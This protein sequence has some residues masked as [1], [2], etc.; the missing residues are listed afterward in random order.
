[1][2]TM[3]VIYCDNILHNDYECNNSS[4]D[5]ATHDTEDLLLIESKKVI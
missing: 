1:M 5:T 4:Q 2:I 3:K